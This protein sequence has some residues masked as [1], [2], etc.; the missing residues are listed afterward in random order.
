MALTYKQL[1]EQGGAYHNARKKKKTYEDIKANS[2]NHLAGYKT[3][4]ESNIG[5]DTLGRDISSL[6]DV[7][8]ATENGW[9]SAND[10]KR[11]KA[12]IE[13]MRN[14]VD[15]YNE[16]QHFFGNKESQI[17][18]LSSAYS[19]ILD[20]WGDLESLYGQFDSADAFNTAKKEAEERAKRE[21]ELLSADLGALRTEVTELENIYATAKTKKEEARKKE[22]AYIDQM[23]AQ[24]YTDTTRSKG[25]AGASKRNT[26]GYSKYMASVGYK[27]IEDIEAALNEKQKYYDEANLFQTEYNALNAKDFEK[28]SK[29]G[30]NVKNPSYDEAEYD[31]A[32]F[33]NRFGGEEVKNKIKFAKEH[34]TGYASANA[35]D[36]PNSPVPVSY[37]WASED[38]QK[39]YEYYLGLEIEGKVKKGT[40][41][42]YL[43]M[44]QPKLEGKHETQIL[45][46]LDNFASGG[47]WSKTAASTLSVSYSLTGAVEHV[48]DSI[49]YDK[50]GVMDDNFYARGSSIIRNRVSQDVDF[51]I[52]NW[53]AF[54]FAY[55]TGMSMADSVAAMGMGGHA[56]G[57]ILALSAAGQGVNDALDR[58]LS[59]DQAFWNGFHS[60]CFE[61]V[62]E[63]I[64]IGKF[65]ENSKATKS[66]F[67]KLASNMITNLSEEEA[68][69]IANIM[70]DNIHGELSHYNIRVKELVDSG[71]YTKSEAEII[72]K[73]ELRWQVA[74]A[75]LSGMVMGG[76][77]TAVG[78][79]P[80]AVNN[81]SQNKNLGQAIRQN[82]RVGD[83][84]DLAS[85]E[86]LYNFETEEAVADIDTDSNTEDSSDEELFDSEEAA[87]LF[88]DSD[89]AEQ[90]SSAYKTY[91][92]YAKKSINANNASDYKVGKLGNKL[93]NDARTV[94]ES[95]GATIE[96]VARAKKV[97]ADLEAFS[98]NTMSRHGEGR[99]RELYGDDETVEALINEGLAS[100]EGSDA[101]NIAKEFRAKLDKGNSLSEK[102]LARL[103]DANNTAIKNE[104]SVDINKRLKELGEK[105][106]VS[107]LAN[108]ISSKIVGQKLTSAEA[109]MIEN[110]EFGK[111]VLT[112]MSEDLSSDSAENVTTAEV[113]EKLAELGETA[114]N[115]AELS[116]II[117]KAAVGEKL[118]P[119]EAKTLEGSDYGKKVLAETSP[120]IAEAVEGMDE[121]DAELFAEVY[122]GTS[123]IEYFMESF[124]LVKDL[125]R[126]NYTDDYILQNSGALSPRQVAQ[127]Y[128]KVVTEQRIA[129]Q[130]AIDEAVKKYEG[131]LVRKANID[132][133]VFNGANGQKLWRNLSSRQ[134]QAITFVK[135]FAQGAGINLK[136]TYNGKYNGKAYNGY[137]DNATNTIVIDA[138]AGFDKKYVSEDAIIPTMSHELTHWMKQKSPELYAKLSKQIF[139]V[140]KGKGL[141]EYDLIAQEKQT[142]PDMSD[143]AARD[144][145]IARASEDLF[146]M[147]EEG[148]KIFD[149]LSETEKKTLVEKIKDII[150]N[151]VDWANELLGLYE[152]KS[153][154]AG[155]L[156]EFKDELSE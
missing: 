78:E 64:S 102:E 45:T 52:G 152:S 2:Q 66:A 131:K 128:S 148:K 5:F 14:R 68:T 95:D 65:F 7:I 103:V 121:A 69:E 23:D 38:E 12:N 156:R 67:G 40:S 100:E 60:G 149:S 13:Y 33:G 79:L 127:V 116:E 20:N 82:E 24:D 153:V 50:T 62:F 130:R 111:Q 55:N 35:P 19:D 135:A 17:K 155:W 147:S 139:D 76:G 86:K 54:D 110:S 106:D 43:A 129:K 122:D 145:I 144:E 96:Q 39:I 99:V 28:Y 47:F 105:G 97:I 8:S 3:F 9:Q 42:N 63:S 32:I 53:D 88:G 98:D 30:A 83:V 27:T 141:T 75:G 72:A 1:K 31:F 91:T 58:G 49:E 84:F 125:A 37:I 81:Y 142:H 61:L 71:E 57:G 44:I 21:K 113:S 25:R 151:L 118:S 90:A 41:D 120:E 59:S 56:G 112:E 146:K 143:D 10:L 114:G 115:V 29:I 15:S 132:D 51:K 36:A 154:E 73:N 26:S 46:N 137:Y 104:T 77:F 6:R 126:A 150:K 18:D 94:L 109:E 92:Q 93:L 70:Y 124:N 89:I 108:A 101:Y 85:D 22:D 74:E 107:K 140:F 11:T 133:S 87:E 16:Y 138:R 119:T 117:S 48:Q 4:L 136:I 134:K 123:D 80:N 34:L